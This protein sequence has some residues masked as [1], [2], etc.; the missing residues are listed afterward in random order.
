[1][2][3]LLLL[4]P[5]PLLVTMDLG[6]ELRPGITS[7][8]VRDS[9]HYI[10]MLFSDAAT[11]QLTWQ[12]LPPIHRQQHTCALCVTALCDLPWSDKYD[13]D[14]IT[15][16]CRARSPSP[17]CRARSPSPNSQEERLKTMSANIRVS[18]QLARPWA[19]CLWGMR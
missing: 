12:C 11:L 1:M 13:C 9:L 5:L 15:N 8:G 4:D 17:E 3:L 10:S 19:T 6:S 7:R 14:N 18:E 16:C 2:L